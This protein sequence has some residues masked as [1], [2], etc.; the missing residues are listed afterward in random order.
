MT[1]L[2]TLVAMAGVHQQHYNRRQAET[3]MKLSSKSGQGWGR[4]FAANM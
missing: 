1:G 2:I 3:Y 4:T